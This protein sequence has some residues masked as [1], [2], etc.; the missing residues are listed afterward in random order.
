[1]GSFLGGVGKFLG[2]GGGET[3]GLSGE[4]I[5]PE[6]IH[7]LSTPEYGLDAGVTLAP[8][9]EGAVG[10]VTTV[11]PGQ[12]VKVGPELAAASGLPTGGLT[13]Q[14]V[15]R[16]GRRAGD[17]VEATQQEE[18]PPPPPIIGTRPK[19]AFQPPPPQDVAFANFLQL[20]KQRGMRP[21]GI[22]GIGSL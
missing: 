22:V 14:D 4:A 15:A 2:A 21:R 20:V 9:G 1:M 7:A 13:A 16:L 18:E 3:S 17:V 12:I 19:R 6:L 11:A 5:S 10:Q 8:M